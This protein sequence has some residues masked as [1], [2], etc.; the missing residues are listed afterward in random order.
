MEKRRFGRTGHASTV[1]ILG[2]FAFSEATQAETDAAMERVIAA[3]VNHIDVAPSYGH[4]ELRLGPWMAQERERF[5]LGCKTMERSKDG[6]TI[7]LRESLARLQTDRF[8]LYQIHAIT[9]MEELDQVTAPGGALE[10]LVAA[11]DEGLVDF[12]GI[13]GHG[14]QSPAIFLEALERFD[15]DS[16]LFPINFKLYAEADYRRDAEQLLRVCREREV[17]TMIIKHIAR[18]PWGDRKQTLNTWYE[19]F[20][21]RE[22]IRQGVNFALSQDV[23]GLCTA[24]DLSVLPLLLEACENFTR[25]DESEQAALIATADNYELIFN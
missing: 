10:A 1:A 12:L 3:G 9:R 14:M 21:D 13:T 23:T 17:G 6:A 22:M 8:D 18:R 24:G 7:E 2:A 11:R 25:L 16:V 5:F 19:P 20:V 4:A 15:F